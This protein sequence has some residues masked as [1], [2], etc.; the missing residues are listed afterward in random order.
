M[1]CVWR[2]LS[3]QT[4]PYLLLGTVAATGEWLHV[5]CPVPVDRVQ[6]RRGLEWVRNS[7]RRS[8]KL[9]GIIRQPSPRC[10]VPTTIRTPGLKSKAE[11]TILSTSTLSPAAM[12][13]NGVSV[14]R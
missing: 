11:E 8:N 2:E 14:N 13:L 1:L 10:G 3:R 4:N 7:I 9:D 5:Y 12:N 6:I